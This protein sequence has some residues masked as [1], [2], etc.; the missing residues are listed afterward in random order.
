M[1]G[2]GCDEELI[3]QVKC[4][5]VFTPCTQMRLTATTKKVPSTSFLDEQSRSDIQSLFSI[6]PESD[7]TIGTCSLHMDFC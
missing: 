4:E 6:Y 3:K 2:E 5:E 7:F 1:K